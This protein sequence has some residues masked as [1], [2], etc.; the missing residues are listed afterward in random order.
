MVVFVVHFLDLLLETHWEPS[1]R[2]SLLPKLTSRSNAILFKL[3]LFDFVGV[4]VVC[5]LCCVLL[6]EAA[7]Y[8]SNLTY[9]MAHKQ[10]TQVP[11]DIPENSVNIFLQNNKISTIADSTFI[12]NTDCE[13]LKLDHNKLEKIT[14]KMWKGLYSLKW[15]D[16]SKNYIKKIES[17][18]FE[19][20]TNLQVL[21]LADNLLK[22]LSEDV[23]PEGHNL[24]NLKLHGNPLPR[25]SLELCW[26]HQGALD[27]WITG[28]T[29]DAQTAA[30]CDEFDNSSAADTSTTPKGGWYF[31]LSAKRDLRI[32]FK[33]L[34]RLFFVIFSCGMKKIKTCEIYPSFEI[35]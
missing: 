35:F 3:H 5:S 29:L 13:D 6:S 16:L 20:L 10:L 18:A 25:D 30:R 21:Y 23:L 4:V 22:F 31:L 32:N 27:G 12:D 24:S 2:Q 19:D 9:N 11:R 34:S 28:F 8:S 15:L 14:K 1:L 7:F 33:I 26:I 17:R